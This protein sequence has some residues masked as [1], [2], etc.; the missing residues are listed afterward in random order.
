MDGLNLYAAYMGVNGVDP[1]GLDITKD[2]LLRAYKALF[3]SDDILLDAF[4]KA[5]HSIKTTDVHPNLNLDYLASSVTYEVNIE[6]DID[7]ATASML[8]RSGMFQVLDKSAEMRKH[9]LENLGYKWGTLEWGIAHRDL[10]ANAYKASAG[11]AADYANGYV[12]ALC[13]LNEGVDLVTS[14]Y[15]VLEGNYWAGIGAL[16]LVPGAAG[17]VLRRGDNVIDSRAI[18]LIDDMVVFDGTL[19]GWKHNVAGSIQDHHIFFK[20]LGG[21]DEALNKISMQQVIHQGHKIGLHQ[22]IMQHMGAKRYGELVAQWN[23]AKYLGRKESQ[24]FINNLK[25]GYSSY[26]SGS[27]DYDA[28]MKKINEALDEVLK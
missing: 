20:S 25:E 18:R 17:K 27:P 9:Y 16:P 10:E 19:K 11:S 14:G 13:V 21:S 2:D 26:F 15:E 5:G 4:N 6:E 23:K 1:F 22:H 12:T 3:G 28:I 8:L 24:S 7:L